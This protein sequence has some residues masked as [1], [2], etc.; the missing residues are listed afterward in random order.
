ML[1]FWLFQQL[2][3]KMPFSGKKSCQHLSVCTGTTVENNTHSISLHVLGL[4]S[5]H[6]LKLWI[7]TDV[8]KD[9]EN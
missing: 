1:N 2:T 5:Y 7:F 9:V 8:E 6:F 4:V 3:D